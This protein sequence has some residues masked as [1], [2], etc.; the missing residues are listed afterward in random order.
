[1]S[2]LGV[3]AHIF[4]QVIPFRSALII[5]DLSPIHSVPFFIQPAMREE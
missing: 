4:N 3:D 2:S 5:N 1:M